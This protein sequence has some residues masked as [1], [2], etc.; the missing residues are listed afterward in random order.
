MNLMVHSPPPAHHLP[1][2]RLASQF[3]CFTGQGRSVNVAM[4]TKEEARSD[5]SL[6]FV[7][8]RTK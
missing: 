2:V 4:T 5:F 6:L 1:K 8:G 7:S 3:P